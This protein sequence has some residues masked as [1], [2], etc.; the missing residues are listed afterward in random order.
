VIDSESEKENVR[1]RKWQGWGWLGE[2]ETDFKPIPKLSCPAVP[3]DYR[4]ISVTAILPRLLE[5]IVVKDY[6]YPPLQ[7]PP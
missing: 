6:I 4:P 7:H 3:S 2:T 1:S 5:R